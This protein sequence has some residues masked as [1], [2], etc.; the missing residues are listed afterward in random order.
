MGNTLSQQKEYTSMP[1]LSS[2]NKKHSLYPKTPLETRSRK[3]TVNAVYE[4]RI[5]GKG[6]GTKAGCS[7]RT[8]KSSIEFSQHAHDIG[9]FD[10]HSW[11]GRWVFQSWS[12]CLGS[13][14]LGLPGRTSIEF[15]H[16]L[17]NIW[18]ADSP[19]VVWM[20]G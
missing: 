5:S 6:R 9:N 2:D 13:I 4:T 11:S 12:L 7:G 20:T 1:W 16:P 14:C 18:T 10:L 3:D 19:F 15:W 8:S 17:Y